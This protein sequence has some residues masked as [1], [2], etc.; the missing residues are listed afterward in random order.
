MNPILGIAALVAALLSL[1]VQL[2]TML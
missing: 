1:G 2:W